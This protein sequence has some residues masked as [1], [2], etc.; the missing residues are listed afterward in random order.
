VGAGGPQIASC[1][2]DFSGIVVHWRDFA[3]FW[4][5]DVDTG[6]CRRLGIELGER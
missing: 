5:R 2:V 4:A 1:G 3:A 6:G